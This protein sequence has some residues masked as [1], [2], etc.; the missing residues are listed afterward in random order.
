MRTFHRARLDPDGE[1]G[2][3]IVIVALALI[4]MFGMVVLVVDVG[5][6][7]WKRRELVNGS[8][9]AALSAAAT[10]ALPST[11]DPKTAE[12]AADALAGQNVTG[13]D[14]TLSTNATT[15]PSTCHTT[16]SGGVKVVYSQSQHLF[17]APVLGFPNQNNVTTKAYAVWGPAGAASPLPIVIYTSSFQGG[18][19]VTAN[20]PPGT[21][22]Y[23]WFDN[24]RFSNSAFGYLN[25]NPTDPQKG[26]DVP[27]D[28]QCPNVGSS[29]R[30]NWINA[31]GSD[32]D[33]PVHYP[34][35][36]TYVCRVSGL[37]NTDWS[38]LRSR[39]GDVVTFPMDDCTQNVD[40]VGNPVGCFGNADKY[41]IIGFIDFE[42]EAVLDQANGANGWGG[43]PTTTCQANNFDVVHNQTYSLIGLGTGSC[44]NATQSAATIDASTLTIDGKGPSDPTRQYTYDPVAK[45]FTWTGP[46]SPPR[47]NVQFDW[48]LAGRC[49][50]PPGNTSAVCILV[51]TVEVRV[52]GSSPCPSC[53]PLSNIRAIK[54]C[55]PSV[56]GS[57]NGITVPTP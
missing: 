4:A 44:P 53:S 3:T 36:P 51:K 5:G 47:I 37:S 12:Q 23:M 49:G 57:C 21:E 22:C 39:Q 19:D 41:D 1:Q 13:L 30:T 11:V 8:D 16:K 15:L 45:T 17:F 10:C 2:A 32:A 48:S 34:N 29:D 6:L 54:L 42:L 20:L 50:T 24:D 27:K 25:L 46:T 38:V 35:G 40:Q 26:W 31:A 43:I 56:A 33:L 18:C 52:G 14:P 55:D 9:A 28:A 7:L